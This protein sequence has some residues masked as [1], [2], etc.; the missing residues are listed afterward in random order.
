[1]NDTVDHKA[2][3]QKTAVIPVRTG[4][5]IL[6]YD[7][8]EHMTHR[9]PRLI[10]RETSGSLDVMLPALIASVVISA[11]VAAVFTL[12]SGFIVTVNGY[13]TRMLETFCWIL[14]LGS[15]GFLLPI[16]R[17][18]K[19]SE[20]EEV[21]KKARERILQF[22]K[23]FEASDP[24]TFKT[25][26]RLMD[27]KLVIEGDEMRP[28]MFRLDTAM[29]AL[30]STL[31]EVGRH[32]PSIDKANAMARATVVRIID[33]HKR[34]MDRI[35]SESDALTRLEHALKDAVDGPVGGTVA[36]TATAP[37]ARISRIVETAEKALASH[38]DLL[39]A[40]GA[41]ID[42]LVRTHVPR[43][44][45]K[46]AEAARTATAAEVAEVDAA[47]DKGVDAVRAS[48]QEALAGLHDQA[49]DEL[50]TE[51]RFLD[52]RRGVPTDRLLTSV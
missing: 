42:D 29:I 16:A 41:R 5:S 40:Q 17:S 21:V 45:Q 32:E 48:V 51:L 44:L 22:S 4:T 12:C 36:L 14:G 10:S 23:S 13:E 43:L 24:Q 7:P 6:P 46:H 26:A 27:E 1:M 9:K 18:M 39:D 33:Q 31:E 11:M 15:A 49:M 52:L 34:D 8:A 37:T 3:D 25:I 28:L 38:P 30:R 35:H 50:V 2:L 20:D 47:L 19:S